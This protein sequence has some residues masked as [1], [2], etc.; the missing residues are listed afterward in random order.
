MSLTK[1]GGLGNPAIWPGA[2]FRPDV[3]ADVFLSVPHLAAH[4]SGEQPVAGPAATRQGRRL[5]FVT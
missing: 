3:G 1:S 2:G 5:N 4:A